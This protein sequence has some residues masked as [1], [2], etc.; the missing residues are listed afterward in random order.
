MAEARQAIAIPLDL[1][2]RHPLTLYRAAAIAAA[3]GQTQ[4]ATTLVSLALNANPR[5]S[6][7][8]AEDAARLQ[9]RLQEGVT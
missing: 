4:E 9:D 2:V 7:R 8:Y 6:M 3:A 5:F 1:G